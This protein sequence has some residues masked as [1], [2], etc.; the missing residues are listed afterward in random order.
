[1]NNWILNKIQIYRNS[2]INA[3]FYKKGRIAAIGMANKLKKGEIIGLT[4][5]QVLR[6]G[7]MVPFFGKKHQHLR[8]QQLCQLN[9]KYQY[10][11]LN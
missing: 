5:D 11:W 4:N 6:E 10:L 3:D 7:I 2:K 1:M 9:G 8:R